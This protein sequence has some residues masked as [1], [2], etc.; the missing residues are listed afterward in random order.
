MNTGLPPEIWLVTGIPGSGKTTVARLL[1]Q[2]LERTAHIEGDRLAEWVVAGRV[3]PGGELAEEAERQTE[4]CIRNQCLLA[5]SYAEAG[6]IPV[7]DYVIPNQY[8]LAAYRN[9]L[10][11]GR[12]HLVVVAPRPEVAL[13]RDRKRE[14]KH[15]GDRWA[16]LD[17]EMR[18]EL[19]GTGL[20][21]DS[22]ELTAQETA[23][24]ILDRR[25]EALLR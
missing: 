20:W 2:R 24:A 15:V 21:L 11:G 22:S 4:L 8:R 14:E 7:I 19:A 13:A 23:A 10:A 9:Y 25:G 18:A 5:R 12:L 17:A 1:A 3:L 6:I 16:H